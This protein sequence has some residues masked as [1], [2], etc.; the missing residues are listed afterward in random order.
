MME[1]ERLPGTFL[2]NLL[3]FLRALRTL[4]FSIG[5]EEET[6]ATQMILVLGVENSQTMKAALR[7][8]VVLRAEQW[9][10]FDLAW[11][12][13]ILMLT[14]SGDRTI[15]D[16]TLLSNIARLR[17]SR[18]AKPQVIWM[19]QHAPEKTPNAQSDNEQMAVSIQIG[20]TRDEVLRAKDFAELTELEQQELWRTSLEIE[21]VM[22]TSRRTKLANR[23]QAFD[24]RDT[25]AQS[26]KTG[27]I[28]HFTRR[29]RVKKPRS[30]VLL[31]DVSG[32]M[33]PYS[34]MF[35]RFAYVLMQKGIDLEAFVFSTRLTRITRALR[36]RNPDQALKDIAAWTPDFSGGT[37]LC[38]AVTHFCLGDGKRWLRSSPIVLVATDGLDTGDVTRLKRSLQQVAFMSQW[39]IW[40][41][42]AYARPNYSPSARGAEVLWQT[43]DEVVPADRWGSLEGL[44]RDLQHRRLHRASRGYR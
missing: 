34:R 6:L 10:L 3:M 26:A 43:A 29:T 21:P 30:V 1:S 20:A 18:N 5:A 44:W 17:Q 22:R 12:Q 28:V 37:R 38:E 39:L 33:D 41:N 24:L 32:S 27:D 14:R 36:V 40:L 35:I 9:A 15:S 7:S 2:S 42:P 13:F 31:C 23:G 19:G 25:I 4:D 11:Q 8:L 16:Q